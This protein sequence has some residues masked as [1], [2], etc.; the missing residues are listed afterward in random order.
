MDHPN[1][2]CSG[3]RSNVPYLREQ[4]MT[5]KRKNTGNKTQQ[6]SGH[7]RFLANL[8][9]FIRYAHLEGILATNPEIERLQISAKSHSW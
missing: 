4:T 9:H 8:E 2:R 5:N 7:R 6:T 3:I 1:F